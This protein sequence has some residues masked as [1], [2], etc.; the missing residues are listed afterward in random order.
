ME[1]VRLVTLAVPEVEAAKVHITFSPRWTNEM[2]SE[3]GKEIM[4]VS[5]AVI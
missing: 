2:V 4:A 1:Q 3:E 5:G